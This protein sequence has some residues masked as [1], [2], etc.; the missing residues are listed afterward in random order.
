MLAFTFH[1]PNLSKKARRFDGINPMTDA[2]IVS[3]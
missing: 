2:K 1:P 3:F